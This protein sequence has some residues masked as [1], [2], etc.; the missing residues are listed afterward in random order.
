M[1]DTNL[2]SIL[3]RDHPECRLEGAELRPY[4]IDNYWSFCFTQDTLEQDEVSSAFTRDKLQGQLSN[5]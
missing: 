1:Y 3:F 5:G 2:Q 4:M